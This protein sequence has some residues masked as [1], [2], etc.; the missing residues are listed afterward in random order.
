MSSGFEVND[1]V[2]IDELQKRE[3]LQ[4]WGSEFAGDE[5]RGRRRE[6]DRGDAD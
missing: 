5:E 3:T 6:L 4:R 1:E 2:K